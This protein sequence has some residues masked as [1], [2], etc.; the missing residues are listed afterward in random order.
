MDPGHTQTQPGTGWLQVQI[1]ATNQSRR[2]F[3]VI[4]ILC[5]VLKPERGC[6][7]R[8]EAANWPHTLWLITS[9]ESQL[10][11]LKPECR[12]TL[13]R[14]ASDGPEDGARI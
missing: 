4:E 13:S 7:A 12:P 8:A 6:R 11:M 3:V 1:A 14:V 5:A 2:K 9:A 10:Q